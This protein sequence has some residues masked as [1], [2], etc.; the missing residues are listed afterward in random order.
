MHHPPLVLWKIQRQATTLETLPQ[1]FMSLGTADRLLFWLTSER[2][3]I[4]PVH[5]GTTVMWHWQRK[6]HP[7]NQ[8]DWSLTPFAKSVY[9]SFVFKHLFIHGLE[10]K[11]EEF[12]HQG[13]GLGGA[14]D[15]APK[16]NNKNNSKIL[17]INPRANTKQQH[18]ATQHQQKLWWRRL[19]EALQRCHY[20]QAWLIQLF[21][22]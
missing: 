6:L 17:R 16:L 2:D 12:L 13:W 21:A 19:Q 11:G 8:G 4:T 7:L 15:K 1:R 10:S 5:Q 14:K 9:L 3:Q 18:S 20:R 22:V